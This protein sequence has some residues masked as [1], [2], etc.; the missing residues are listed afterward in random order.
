MLLG[1]GFKRRGYGVQEM[2]GGGP[3]SGVDLVLTKAGE[4]TSCNASS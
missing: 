4:K 1:E 3:V 2:G